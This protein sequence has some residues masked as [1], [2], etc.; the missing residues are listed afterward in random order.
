MA[1]KRYNPKYHFWTVPYFFNPLSIAST[2]SCSSALRSFHIS[3]TSVCVSVIS[4][5][6]SSQKNCDSV[7]S[8]AAH[9]FSSVINEGRLSVAMILPS[10]NWEIPDNWDNLYLLIPHFLHNSAILSATYFSNRKQIHLFSSS[11]VIILT[12][13][14]KKY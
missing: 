3:K 11:H 5:M 1:Q 12:V 8:N 13:I 9:I 2:T 6:S 10:E 14:T 4:F 7:T